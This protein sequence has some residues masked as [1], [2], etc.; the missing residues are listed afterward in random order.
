MYN[1][2]LNIHHKYFT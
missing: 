2:L 1:V